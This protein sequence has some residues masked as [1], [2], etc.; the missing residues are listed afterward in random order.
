[1]PGYEL[2]QYYDENGERRGVGS[3]D[4]NDYLREISG[5]EMSA[6]DFRTWAGTLHA[7]AALLECG[8]CDDEREAKHRVKESIEKVAERLGNTP[9][10]C[11][12]CYVHPVVIDRYL[13]GSLGELLRPGENGPV[14]YE[15]LRGLSHEESA[16]LA[17]LGEAA[18]AGL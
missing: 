9:A 1:V 14:R 12:A 3:G 11:R 18:A 13:D 16:V 10:V 8:P 6:K 5:E 4:V 15:K 17:L 7:A 2:F